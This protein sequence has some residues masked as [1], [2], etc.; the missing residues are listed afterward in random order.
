MAEEDINCFLFHLS[1]FVFVM[2]F[3]LQ[4]TLLSKFCDFLSTVTDIWNF[5]SKMGL[6][7]PLIYCSFL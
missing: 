2:H 3:L 7:S 5:V 6:R 4:A 1:N